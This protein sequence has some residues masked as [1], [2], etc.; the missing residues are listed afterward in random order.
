MIAI[1]AWVR[2][3]LPK[4]PSPPSLLPQSPRQS[5]LGNG[6]GERL[7]V[8]DKEQANK[9]L[10]NIADILEKMGVPY[11]IDSGT[12]L[13]AYRDRDFIDLDHDIDVRILPMGCPEERMLELITELWKRDFRVLVQN[14][15]QR[16]ELI[17]VN[18]DR[19][20][21]DLKFAYTDGTYLWLYI[22][23]APASREAPRVHLYPIRF[24]FSLGEI[25]LRG[26]KY[27]TPEP[28]EEY[29]VCHYGKEWRQ[30][31]SRSEQA[32]DTDLKW[33]YR[34]SPPCAKSLEELMALR[35]NGH[36]T[37]ITAAPNEAVEKEGSDVATG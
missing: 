31:K 3:M 35:N 17:C 7:K 15:G 8:L 25:E 30:F 22:W 34:F 37:E 10:N 14:Y 32:E 28:I 23:G 24:F 13:G 1:P 9:A 16:A 20:M 29:L 26:R 6:G 33:D 36:Q 21:L 12:L 11:W 18:T 27:P 4:K 19:V 5:L 2:D